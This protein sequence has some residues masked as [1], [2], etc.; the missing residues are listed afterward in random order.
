MSKLANIRKPVLY[1]K[2]QLLLS[3][4][5]QLDYIH[6][7]INLELYS[8]SGYYG[9]FKTVNDETLCKLYSISERKADDIP[10][11]SDMMDL[12]GMLRVGNIVEL[13]DINIRFA[14]FYVQIVNSKVTKLCIIPTIPASGFYVIDLVNYF[15]E[16]RSR[17]K[18][19]KIFEYLIYKLLLEI[20]LFGYMNDNE[21]KE[22]LVSIDVYYNRSKD[23]SG[24]FHRDMTFGIG[25]YVKHVSLE[26][27]TE[28]SEL[29]LGPEVVLKSIEGE[30]PM[31]YE[32]S[33]YDS[34]D[35]SE[36]NQR[37]LR[38]L[39]ENG[40]VI[41]FNNLETIHATP[42]TEL[43]DIHPFKY[44]KS[45]LEIK[46]QENPIIK[47]TQTLKRSFIRCWYASNQY[48]WKTY[49]L[50]ENYIELDINEY[51]EI[52][53]IKDTITDMRFKKLEEKK[54][55]LGGGIKVQ[56]P[57]YIQPKDDVQFIKTNNLDNKIQNINKVKP[58]NI[59]NHK[60]SSNL[61]NFNIYGDPLNP[62]FTLNFDLPF[63]EIKGEKNIKDYISNEM[64]FID[65]LMI[66]KGGV[67]GRKYLKKHKN[68]T[69]KNR[70]TKKN[71]KHKNGKNVNTKKIKKY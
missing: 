34:S 64:S 43:L 23:R 16:D 21:T 15:I 46:D 35:I 49:K 3:R 47:A 40:T 66:K 52:F 37:S 69:K 58:I 27:F 28:S 24:L 19:Y 7:S 26:Y 41:L 55:I 54:D 10:E 30:D 56:Q 53:N 65:R 61:F 44:D 4:Y 1:G 67:N 70:K 17:M 62:G 36:L 20:T 60:Y 6:D 71:Y 12:E 18:Y 13:N 57:F 50:P 22:I 32:G 25:S 2:Q 11:T 63:Q 42:I 68:K 29:F 14:S 38:L 59:I 9:I 5:K 8:D 45:R 48:N 51:L 33:A 39:A 31:L